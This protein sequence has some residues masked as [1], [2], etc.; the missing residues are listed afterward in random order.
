MT[1]VKFFAVLSLYHNLR[2]QL[3]LICSKFDLASY[4]CSENFGNIKILT[5]Y[6]PKYS[7]GD[8]YYFSRKNSQTNH[9]TKFDFA[10]NT[11]PKLFKNSWTII[12]IDDQL[13]FFYV[14]NN[15]KIV[16]NS[17]WFGIQCITDLLLCRSHD[18]KVNDISKLKSQI[19]T[20]NNTW[21]SQWNILN[22]VV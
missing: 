7:V 6:F 5:T 15:N 19:F 22:T 13:E 9:C 4:T 14:N 16:A 20:L 8:A 11:Y 17:H 3:T 12:N 10:P 21:I 2:T 18:K 1:V